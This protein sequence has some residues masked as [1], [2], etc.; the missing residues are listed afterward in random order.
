MGRE[1]GQNCQGLPYW[2]HAV[3][4]LPVLQSRYDFP[5][6]INNRGYST[7][8]E[9]GVEFGCFSYYLLEH[10]KLNRLISVDSWTSTHGH[11]QYLHCLS[12]LSIFGSRSRIYRRQSIDAASDLDHVPLDFVY[13][14]AG[15]SRRA[16]LTDMNIWWPLIRPG[17]CMAG[18]DYIEIEKCGVVAAVHRFLRKHR[19]VELHLTQEAEWKSWYIFKPEV[20]E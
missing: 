9:V 18:H 14:D 11:R 15:H 5:S 7:A 8:V 10:S 2:K 16:C 17:G 3:N 19:D 6:L 20:E 13:I 12:L 1:V 4:D